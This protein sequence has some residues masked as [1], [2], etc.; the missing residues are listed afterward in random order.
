MSGTVRCFSTSTPSTRVS[1][2][3]NA[4]SLKLIVPVRS[5]TAAS[6]PSIR[7]REAR[8]VELV[9]IEH[10]SDHGSARVFVGVDLL[11]L[12]RIDGEDVT[13][14][15]VALRGTGAAIA[16]LAEAGGQRRH[17]GGNVEY[18][19]MPPPAPGRRIGVVHGY[20]EA[21]GTCRRVLPGERRRSVAAVAAEALVHLC[22]GDRRAGFDLGALERERAGGE[23]GQRQRDQ[24]ERHEAFHYVLLDEVARS[25]LAGGGQIDHTH[26]GPLLL[27]YGQS[28]HSSAR[29][30]VAKRPEHT[31]P[32]TPEVTNMAVFC[33]FE[34]IALG[35]Q[36]AKY[37]RF[38][39]GKVLERLL[40]KGS[41]VVKK[42]Y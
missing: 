2:S 42:A 24:S 28:A 15:L 25:S 36:D 34:N 31:M 3:D 10:E 9:G 20:R 41:I 39:I 35:V 12:E 32:N 30:P 17:V 8:F 27:S 1:S 37:D 22:R 4:G 23:H 6:F 16:G 26:P 40:L 14:R 13:M 7:C 11:H 5:R 19:P 29:P 18:D 38:D 21:L 33:D